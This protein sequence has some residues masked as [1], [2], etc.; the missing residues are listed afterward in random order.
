MTRVRFFDGRLLTAG[1]FDA[2]QSYQ[3]E[4]RKLHNRLLHGAGV[5]AGL[6][7][8]DDDSGTAIIVSL[9]IAI[10]GMG[11][12]IIVGDTV[13]VDLGIRPEDECFV[14]IRYGET[15]ADPVPMIDGEVEFSRVIESF[16]IAII[17]NDPCFNATMQEI[18]LARLIRRNGHWA[19]DKTYA[20]PEL[21]S[22]TAL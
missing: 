6:E 3:M 1:D 17:T 9:G 10:D 18:G 11:N 13:H 4:K 2:E 19:I 15:P 7:V 21:I 20:R 14:T 16:A 12:E 8:S 22:R 5:A